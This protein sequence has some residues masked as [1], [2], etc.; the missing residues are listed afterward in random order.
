MIQF[1]CK[2][3]LEE[4]VGEVRGLNP[5]GGHDE[6]EQTVNQLLV[7]MDGFDPRAGVM[8]LAVTNCPDILDPALLRM[9]RSDH[10]A[11]TD[12]PDIRG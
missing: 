7:E 10:H 3:I 1:I 6:R 4:T 5:M 12:K 9:G 2:W 8:I 11:A